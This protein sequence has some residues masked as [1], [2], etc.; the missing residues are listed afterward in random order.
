MTPAI[1]GPATA[2]LVGLVVP[3]ALLVAPATDPAAPS[4]APL[5]VHPPVTVPRAT[6]PPATTAP[7]A[8]PAAAVPAGESVWPLYPRPEVVTG[9]SPPTDPWGAGHRGVD[10]LGSVGQPVRSAQAGTV[11]YVGTIAGVGVVVVRHGRT[12]S[13]YQPVDASV[14]VGQHVAA[15]QVLGT[16]ALFGSHCGLRACLHWGL[17]DGDRYLDPLT[18][19]GAAPVRLL[20]LS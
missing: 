11:S 7:F 9:F 2:L 10:L 19:V 16:L 15:G 4:T 17:L 18:L 8:G 14:R 13:T 20:P 6:V 3:S 1:A 5:A 12:R